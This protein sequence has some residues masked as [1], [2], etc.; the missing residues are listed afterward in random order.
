MFLIALAAI[1]GAQVRAFDPWASFSRDRMAS[2]LVEVA[3]L[4]GGDAGPVHY[5]LRLTTRR[6]RGHKP[7]VRWADSIA[8]PAIGAV[9]LGMDG[10]AMPHPGAH[11][12]D[13]R[14]EGR[15]PGRRG[16]CADRTVD[17]H[18]GQ[19]DDHVDRR[20]AARG[21]DQ[22]R[23]RAARAVLAHFRNGLEGVS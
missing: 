12:R 4:N 13:A 9:V 2:Q 17:L 21:L 14:A 6:L 7:E 18:H 22:R 23:V 16:L 3:T 8:C 15:G 1:V 20:V 10:L 11:R 19:A 5:R